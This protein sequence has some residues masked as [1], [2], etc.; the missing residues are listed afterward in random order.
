PILGGSVIGIFAV[1]GFYAAQRAGMFRFLGKVVAHVT[2]A[3]EWQELVKH[4][5]AL[6]QDIRAL[7]GRRRA[8]AA[9][10]FWHMITW[11]AGAVEV[12]IALRAL[13]VSRAT[14]PKAY[15]L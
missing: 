7:Y 3:P 2:K 15:V 5:D 13:G 6:D 11:A 1:A 9:S 8:I 10:A 12:W 14:Y 4:G